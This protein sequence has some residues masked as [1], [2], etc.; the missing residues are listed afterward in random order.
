[1]LVRSDAPERYLDQRM[2]E[3][4]PIDSLV[5]SFGRS[6]SALSVLVTLL[7]NPSTTLWPLF[8]GNPGPANCQGF[9]A[10]FVVPCISNGTFGYFRFVAI[11]VLA[12]VVVGWLP[13]LTAVPHVVVLYMFQNSVGVADGGDAIALVVAMLFLPI[14][15]VDRR[16]WHWSPSD[17]PPRDKSWQ[18]PALFQVLFTLQVGLVYL[19]A[20]IGKLDEQ[21]WADGS[22]LWYW[23]QNQNFGFPKSIE[24]I[25]TWLLTNGLV[26]NL[27]TWSVL[28][29]E[30]FICV[31]ALFV[32]K[33]AKPA[34]VTGLTFHL[35]TAVL[36]G[37]F[38]FFLSASALLV[39]GLGPNIL[40][41]SGVVERRDVA[42]ALIRW[43]VVVLTIFGVALS[44]L[45]ILSWS[46]FTGPITLIAVVFLLAIGLRR[47][48]RAL[49]TI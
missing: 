23:A 31:T 1:M 25:T 17:V 43:S 21:E 33:W 34:L 29:A 24:P 45:T 6:L 22:G 46:D 2:R 14:S 8:Q 41:Q 11:V 10:Q 37:L 35:L 27:A 16:K 26:V 15:I 13:R 40:T 42:S 9:A 20:T 48:D 38:T 7:V 12:L 47:L 3:C 44:L 32:R 39:L 30:G 5:I 36:M 28:V 49:P 18:G 4:G 19:H